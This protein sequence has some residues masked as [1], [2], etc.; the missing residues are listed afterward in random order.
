MHFRLV[1]EAEMYYDWSEESRA[2]LEGWRPKVL[3]LSFSDKSEIPVSPSGQSG[4][5]YSL[6]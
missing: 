1:G 3:S 4:I 5:P 6:S 2:F